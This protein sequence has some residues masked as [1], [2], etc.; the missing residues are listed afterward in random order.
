MEE[1][2][3]VLVINL[4][5]RL[6]KMNHVIQQL[7]KV[8]LHQNIIRINAYNEIYAEQNKFKYIT[9]RARDNIKSSNNSIVLPNYQ[10]LACCL[11]HRKTWKYIID[12]DLPFAIIVED[13][14]EIIN[15]EKFL[16]QYNHSL[17]ILENYND[18]DLKMMITLNSKPMK[19]L[20]PKFFKYDLENIFFDEIKKNGNI[21]YTNYGKQFSHSFFNYHY[22]NLNYNELASSICKKKQNNKFGIITKPFIGTHFYIINQ[23]MAKYLYHNFSLFTYQLDIELGYHFQKVFNQSH[24]ILGYNIETDSIIQSKNFESDIQF[25]IFTP[26]LISIYLKLPLDVCTNIWE[27]IPYHFRANTKNKIYCS[28][29]NETKCLNMKVRFI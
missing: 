27:F 23:K 15:I 7:I 2:N 29:L 24:V 13:D 4:P 14:I 3:H 11:S 6:N 20:D 8:N 16:F 18:K 25:K 5:N 28:E 19:N 1:Y 10:S 21:C 17:R 12:H 22:S 9:L 26:I